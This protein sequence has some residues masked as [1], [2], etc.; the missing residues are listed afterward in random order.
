MVDVDGSLTDGDAW[1]TV[2][3]DNN[4]HHIDDC[5]WD[6][7]TAVSDSYELLGGIICSPDVQVRGVSFTSQTPASNFLGQEIKI[8]PWDAS[9]ISSLTEEELEEYK[10]NEDNYANIAFDDKA[11]IEGWNIPLAT[12]HRYLVYWGAAG[13]DFEQMQVTLSGNWFSDD[14]PIGIVHNHTDTRVYVNATV[15]TQDESW[16]LGVGWR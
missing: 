3:A 11:P 15:Y 7:E 6:D 2:V 4:Q 14:E 12:G 13:L 5:V 16:E 1:S 10:S 9:Y 8:I